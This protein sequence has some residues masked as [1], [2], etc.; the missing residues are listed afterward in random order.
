[1]TDA[2][3]PGSHV[4]TQT[5]TLAAP[6]LSAMLAFDL[7]IGNRAGMFVSPS[8]LDFSTPALNQQAR[9]DILVAGASPFSVAPADVLMNVFQTNPGDPA[10]SGYTH[11]SVNLTTFLNA[12]VGTP[13]T[14]RFAETD[15]VLTF[16][17]G[18]DNVDIDVSAAA[19]PEPSSALLAGAALVAIGCLMRRKARA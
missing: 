11:H 10:V 18:V 8:S 13:L 6:V 14:L 1:M 5:F 9:V 19:V 4:M 15:N 2:Q 17:L 7:F 16:Q 12:H 3:G